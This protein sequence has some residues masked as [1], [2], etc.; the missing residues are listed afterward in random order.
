MMKDISDFKITVP[1]LKDILVKALVV[2]TGGS[3][4]SKASE[5]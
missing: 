1:G 4:A 5:D 2:A 3:Q